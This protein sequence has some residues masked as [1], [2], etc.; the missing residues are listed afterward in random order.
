MKT[1]FRMSSPG[2]IGVSLPELDVPVEASI[3][4]GLTR[5]GDGSIGLPEASEGQILRHFVNLSTMN[6]HV[7]KGMYPLGSC[8]MKYNPKINEKIAS[9]SG[10][11][12]IHPHL[13]DEHVQGALEL[14]YNLCGFLAEITGMY[15]CSLQPRPAPRENSPDF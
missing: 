3:P 13:P 2:R 14:M 7:D 15:A 4:G 12:E 11:S 10:F 9:F 1:I 8:T 5:E 6:Y